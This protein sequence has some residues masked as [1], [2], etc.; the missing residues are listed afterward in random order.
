MGLFDGYSDPGTY[1]GNSGG[2]IDRLL[3]QLGTQNQYQPG[4]GFPQ[5]DQNAAP[6]GVGSY[7]MPRA[8]NADLYQPQQV[9][10]PPASQ[11]TQ[12]QYQPISQPGESVLPRQTAE[13]RAAGMLPAQMQ[14]QQSPMQQP[15]FL[16]PQGNGLGDHL[17]AGYQTLHGGGGLIGGL[18]AGITGQRVDDQGIALQQQQ[19]NLR[20]QY[21][22]L[23]SAGLSPQKALLATVNPEYAKTIIPQ[24]F[25]GDKYSV[26]QTG[27]NNLGNKSYQVFDKNTG[28][29]KPI[30][31]AATD[32]SGGGLGNMDL[33]GK[34]YLA[35]LPKAQANIVQGMVEGTIAPPSSFALAK[36][37]WTNM[38]A[39]AKNYDPTFDATNWG[40]RV[41]GTKDFSSGKSSEMVRSANQTI[42]HIGDLIDKMD[43]LKN[44]DYPLKNAA[45]NYI[46]SQTGGAAVT[47]FQQTAHAVADEL[48]KVFKGAGISDHEIKQ[49]EENLSPNMSPAQ[50][51]EAVTTAM[52]LLQHSLSALEEKRLNSIGP[53]AAEKAG[54]LLKPDAQAAIDR[55]QKW[56]GSNASAA[57]P[58]PLKIGESAT[59]GDATIKRVK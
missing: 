28:E 9:M 17:T 54:P 18:I 2:L 33:S 52:S 58:A 6:I 16:Q 26:V 14:P 15:T 13:E 46:N 29:L 5:P 47:G 12:G 4:T 11:P 55:I 24:Q 40:G 42:G 50:Q 37:Y 30:A 43:A 35:S 20:A 38:V 25:G 59:V 49:W 48:S 32:N 7:Q 1:Q 22:A 56:A 41:A 53:M 44:G 36:P 10:T 39:A 57:V 51:R 21:Q 31:G 19:Q 8:G 23:I 45:G 27:E 34:D 3:A